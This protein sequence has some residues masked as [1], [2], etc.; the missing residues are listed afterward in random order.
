MSNEPVEI[1]LN[2]GDIVQLKSGSHRM[3]I[4]A[5]FSH[6]DGEKV[7]VVWSNFTDGVIMRNTFFVSSVVKAK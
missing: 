6:D 1:V 3:V 7:T 2:A 5:K 4:E